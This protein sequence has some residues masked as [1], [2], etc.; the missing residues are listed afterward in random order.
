M[1]KLYKKMAL[2]LPP[3]TPTWRQRYFKPTATLSQKVLLIFRRAFM[4]PLIIVI[5]QGSSAAAEILLCPMV[6]LRFIWVTA[7]FIFTRRHSCLHLILICGRTEE[8]PKSL[9]ILPSCS[10]TAPWATS[11]LRTGF[12]QWC[13]VQCREIL[14]RCIVTKGTYKGKSTMGSSHSVGIH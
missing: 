4:N 7:G 5:H 14:R 6:P 12:Y 8:H 2:I 13:T 9:H 1:K 10:V 3:V 11:P